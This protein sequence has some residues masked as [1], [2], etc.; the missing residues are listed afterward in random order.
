MRI[1]TR[2]RAVLA[3]EQPAP[4]LA[5]A[6]DRAAEQQEQRLRLAA[7]EE[8][9]ATARHRARQAQE[10]AEDVA[11]RESDKERARFQLYTHARRAAAM[12]APITK[13]APRCTADLVW[14][15]APCVN[16]ATG[17]DGA[18]DECR[19]ALLELA[20]DADVNALDFPTEGL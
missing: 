12:R 13:P 10:H 1:I 5:R 19:D 16:V 7:A 6:R 2:L 8:R 18:C 20:R 11:R 17:P 4:T 9:T 15:S 14:A 3:A